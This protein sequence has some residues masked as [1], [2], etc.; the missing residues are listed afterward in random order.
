M[1]DSAILKELGGVVRSLRARRGMTRR[2][3]SATS[4]VSERYLAQLEQ[5]QG[6]ISIALLERVAAALQT[7]VGDLLSRP[8]NRSAEEAL[9]LEFL[10]ALDTDEQKAV[11]E[12]LYDHFSAPA[13]PRQ[14]IAL[15]G[16]RGSGKTTLGN[17]LSEELCIP[18]IRLSAEVET[19]AGMSVS[20]IFSLSGQAGYRRLEEQS[21]MDTLKSYSRCVIETG[22]SIG[23]DPKPL[24]TLLSACFVIWLKAEPEIY[25]QR[26]IKQGDL[27]PMKNNDD[28]LADLRRILI[29]RDPQYSRAH[30]VIDTSRLDLE[31]S[32][33]A[34]LESIPQ[35][36]LE[37]VRENGQEDTN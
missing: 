9:I 25:M 7:S 35:E 21:M 37:Q 4:H 17:M 3:L 20:E 13:G 19:L 24:N 11:L 30:V 23:T 26:V 6:N 15:M 1:Q 18:F 29:E 27:R 31:D 22:G 14:R 5:G 33:G 12:M 34:I 2:E 36:M 10:R 32:L 28:A 16:L 8:D